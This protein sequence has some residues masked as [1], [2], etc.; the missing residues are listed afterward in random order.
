MKKLLFILSIF[1]VA[2]GSSTPPAE[3]Q[4]EQQ[5]VQA[6]QAKLSTQDPIP[7]LSNSLDRKQIIK[8]LKL[9][10]DANKVSYIYFLS[11]GKVI[12]FYTIKGKVT[13]GKKRLTNSQQL[14]EGYAGAGEY[15]SSHPKSDVI[16]APELDGTYGESGDYIFFWTTDDT[17]VQW[18]GEYMLC[19]KP[20]KMATQP[21][22]VYNIDPNK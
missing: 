5:K 8:R 18:N 15:G 4:S 9:F 11:F 10:E 2:C 13:S 3:M 19:D 17:Y 1:L 7:D 14:V 22:I 21:E 6:N 16:N 12:S 20:L